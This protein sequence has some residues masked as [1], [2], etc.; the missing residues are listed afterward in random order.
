MSINLRVSPKVSSNWFDDSVFIIRCLIRF[1][2]TLAWCR[3]AGFIPLHMQTQFPWH[4]LIKGDKR[5]FFFSE[6]CFW[7]LVKSQEQRIPSH[8]P[9]PSSVFASSSTVFVVVVF[10]LLHEVDSYAFKFWKLSSMDMFSWCISQ[11]YLASL[12]ELYRYL[13]LI[14]YSIALVDLSVLRIFWWNVSGSADR[15]NCTFS[16]HIWILLISFTHLIVWLKF[17]EVYWTE[18]LRANMLVMYCILKGSCALYPW[19]CFPGILHVLIY[20]WWSHTIFLMVCLIYACRCLIENF[21]VC[22]H[23]SLWCFP[24]MSLL[25]L[26]IGIMLALWKNVDA[27]LSFKL[28]GMAWGLLTLVILQST[29]KIHPY[30]QGSLALLC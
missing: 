10:Y 5:S 28:H 3:E 21:C 15:G 18:A 17:L 26:G 8:F 30:I 27:S 23:Q 20:L 7:S 29:G 13:V 9:K 22:L 16:L 12:Q 14:L 11:W 2:F 4:C 1:Y 25:G 6:V 19:F 24:L